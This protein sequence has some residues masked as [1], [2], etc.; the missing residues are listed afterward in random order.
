M[1]MPR[2]CRLDNAECTDVA[3]VEDGKL[4]DCADPNN[5]NI[6]YVLQAYIK[7][8]IPSVLKNLSF[9]QFATPL[10]RS[11][12]PLLSASMILSTPYTSGGVYPHYNR[13]YKRRQRRFDGNVVFDGKNAFRLD[14]S[15][16]RWELHLTNESKRIVFEAIEKFAGEFE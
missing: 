16:V 10:I 6:V 8:D 7:T 14:G 12:Y 1:P 13:I 9:A 11:T 3:A 4:V 15:A 5:P 2:W